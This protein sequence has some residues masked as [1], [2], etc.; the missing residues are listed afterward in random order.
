MSAVDDLKRGSASFPS[1][2]VEAFLEMLMAERGA[3]RNT[4][5]AYQRDL[6]HFAAF[7]GA[8]GKSIEAAQS[9]DLRAYLADLARAA[10]SPRTVAR[11]L[12][13]LRQFFRF[14]M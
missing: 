3:A 13:T 14:L 11:R 4:F 1:R 6:G 9:V 8:R 2:F 7:A 10:M 5:A 12:S